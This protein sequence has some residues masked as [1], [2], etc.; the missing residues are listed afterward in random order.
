MTR[1]RFVKIA[2]SLGIPRNG[3]EVIAY[4]IRKEGHTYHNG[5]KVLFKMY[6]NNHKNDGYN[7]KLKPMPLR[8]SKP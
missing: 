4:F 7:G 8:R 1:K 3:A 5:S 6:C 2:M